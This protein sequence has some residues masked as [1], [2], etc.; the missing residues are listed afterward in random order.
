[1]K[2]LAKTNSNHKNN[3]AIFT[4]SDGDYAVL[5]LTMFDSVREHYPDADLYLF[6]IGTGKAR[7]VDNDINI[8]YIGEIIDKL[9]LNQRLAFYLQ[10][11][12]ATSIRPQCFQHL[13]SKDYESVIYLDPD[14]YIFR[15]MTEVDELLDSGV[16]GIVT[17]HALKSIKSKICVSGDN[18][19]LMCGIFN[20]GF[21][22]LNNTD[23]SKRMISWWA[24]KLKWECI[25]DVK[26]G[27]FVDQKWLEFLPIYFD[28]F[29]ILKLPTYNLAPWNSEHYKILKD[30]NNKFYID[31]YQTPIA[32]IH[33]SGAKRSNHHF[34]HM[35]D[36]YKFYV[37]KLESR[38]FVKLDFVNIDVRHEISGLHFDK[39]CTFLYKD[40]V[41]GKN[42]VESDPLE[43]VEFY[44][45]LCST[46]PET[47]LPLY[48]RKLFEVFPDIFVS[49]FRENT[50]ITYDGLIQKLRC[51]FPYD[52]VVNLETMSQICID[53][54]IPGVK[55]LHSVSK[56]IASKRF[57]HLKALEALV[58]RSNSSDNQNTL[59]I[60]FK[61]DRVEIYNQI[62][63]VCIPRIDEYCNLRNAEDIF[64]QNYT[65]IWVPTSFCKN[66]ICDMYNLSNVTAIPYPVVKPSYEIQS[67][68]LSGNKFVVMICHDFN[69]DSDLQ[70]TVS[71]INAFNT[72]FDESDDTF[73]VCFLRNVKYSDVYD[74]ILHQLKSKKNTKVVL[75]GQG[76]ADY[77]SY[78]HHAHCLLSLHKEL[79]FGYRLAEAMRLGKYV[80]ATNYGGNVDFMNRDNSFLIE[81]GLTDQFNLRGKT[82]FYSSEPSI[83][84]AAKILNVIYHESNFLNMKSK[85]ARLSIQ[86]NLSPSSIAYI[87]NNR[88]N[89]LTH[90]QT[91][92]SITKRNHG[93]RLKRLVLRLFDKLFN[94]LRNKL[95]K[96]KIMQ[97]LYLHCKQKI[98]TN[99]PPVTSANVD[100]QVVLSII[101]KIINR[102]GVI[103]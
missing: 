91:T 10:V 52:A 40:F 48:I 20:L 80:V 33:Y 65:E 8:I 12:L 32:F 60:S 19:F 42:D 1:M 25:V 30:S 99:S 73:L 2:I 74:N 29:H 24:E 103:E 36:A 86:K 92:L 15:R 47:N 79:N 90:L 61:P 27:F 17:P 51:G 13:F 28:G 6:V 88:I 82:S 7:V 83:K 38:R 44:Q 66:K 58:E 70:N 84:D 77:Y 101:M 69:I 5:G 21:L 18:T 14:L 62:V 16:N 63:K 11:E 85:N 71:A 102:P 45:Y 89:E 96:Y 75:E 55:F 56:G 64:N 3:K 43:G 50:K 93:Y 59:T 9:D 35:M 76:D 68:G 39:I 78:L 67:T 23:E 87:I 31:N 46:D 54:H 41:L 53:T 57:P 72:A 34:I 22:A 100:P 97:K 49:Y 98:V 94:I 26:N 95:R 4:V 37:D 81:S